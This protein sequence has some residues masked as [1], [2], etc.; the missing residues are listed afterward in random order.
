MRSS[1]DLCGDRPEQDAIF[2]FKREWVRSRGWGYWMVIISALASPLEGLGDEECSWTMD[3]RFKL[4]ELRLG[5][6]FPCHTP[7]QPPPPSEYLKEGNRC[8]MSQN[9]HYHHYP[10]IS[11]T[12]SL[13][14]SCPGSSSWWILDQVPA[15]T[16]LR[17]NLSTAQIFKSS[18]FCWT[19][20]FLLLLCPLSPLSSSVTL[21]EHTCSFFPFMILKSLSKN[22]HLPPS[23]TLSALYQMLWSLSDLSSKLVL[24]WSKSSVLV[25]ITFPWCGICGLIFSLGSRWGKA[26]VLVIQPILP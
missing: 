18:F 21:I 8:G 24:W 2:F 17:G 6:P 11:E 5:F 1:H 19:E 20:D 16:P 12:I 9:C 23:S 22:P 10:W 3:H 13:T 15:C 25:S 4:W 7:N 26:T 14:T